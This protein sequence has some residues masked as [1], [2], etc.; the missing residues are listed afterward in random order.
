MAPIRDSHELAKPLRVER[1][2]LRL[3]KG[4][5]ASLVLASD[6]GFG[7][8]WAAWKEGKDPSLVSCL[9]LGDE[10]G[11]NGLGTEEGEAA[12]GPVFLGCVGGQGILWGSQAV[13]IEQLRA[14]S[15]DRGQPMRKRP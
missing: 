11:E 14:A 13:S 5:S 1:D 9:G 4:C 12:C 6:Q 3:V 2:H 8:K 15:L 10:R 7:N